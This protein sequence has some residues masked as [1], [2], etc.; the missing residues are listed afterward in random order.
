MPE[1]LDPAHRRPLT[2]ARTTG[3]ARAIAGSRWALGHGLVLMFEF[4]AFY[5]YLSSSELIFEDVFDRRALLAWCFAAGALLQAGGNLAASRLVP[6]LGTARLMTWV[7][8]GYL[9]AGAVFLA[10]TAAARGRPSFLPWLGLLFVLNVLHALVLTT[11]N[12]QAMQPLA[13]LAGIGSGLIGTMSMMGAA[14]MSSVVA[15]TI[16]G[17]ATPMAAAYAGFGLLAALSLWWARGGRTDPI[18]L[19]HCGQDC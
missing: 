2:F 7:V 5:V 1:T 16:D 17:S 14:I 15:S 6:R 11:A 18:R 3:A 13:A 9:V 10:V 4:T 12:S 8:A 19:P